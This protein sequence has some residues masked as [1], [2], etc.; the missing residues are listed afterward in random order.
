MQTFLTRYGLHS[1]LNDLDTVTLN[2]QRR[3]AKSVAMYILG[4]SDAG[5]KDPATKMWIGHEMALLNYGA[6]A[7]FI[8]KKRGNSDE[9]LTWFASEAKRFRKDFPG[10]TALAPTWSRDA[11]VIR[12][13]RAALVRKAPKEYADKWKGVTRNMPVLWPD[14]TGGSHRNYLSKA[15]FNNPGL[16]LPSHL[17][18]NPETREVTRAQ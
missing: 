13:H 9:M 11:D 10:V 1:A 5:E 18:V 7:A 14:T 4:I 12:S 3:D 6:V 8:W 16:V 2:Q 15:D 17:I